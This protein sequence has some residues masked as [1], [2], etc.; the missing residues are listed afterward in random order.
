[1]GGLEA[2]NVRL[3]SVFWGIGRPYDT[4]E[5]YCVTVDNRRKI[6]N[7]GRINAGIF[8]P[9]YVSTSRGI[10]VGKGCCEGS[11]K[12]V[13]FDSSVRV[14]FGRRGGVLQVAL[15]IPEAAELR[16]NQV[17]CCE[18]C[19]VAENSPWPFWWSC[20]WAVIVYFTE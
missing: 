6:G 12:R 7:L 1:M 20:A 3:N 5:G 14:L 2:E 18:D 11:A 8:M 4:K 10:A 9:I 19:F 16:S 17:V 13:L 15:P